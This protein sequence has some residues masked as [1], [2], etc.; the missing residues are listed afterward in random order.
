MRHVVHD[1]LTILNATRFQVRE[2]RD[3][4]NSLL[5]YIS[6]TYMEYNSN[7]D[8]L[9]KTIAH[10]TIFSQLHAHLSMFITDVHYLLTEVANHIQNLKL[11]LNMLSLRHLSPS[12]ITPSL[13][14][15]TLTDIQA[16]LPKSMEL[17]QNPSTNLWEYY[18]FLQCSTI[19]DPNHIIILIDIPLLDSFNKLEVYH[20]F[21]L[22]IFMNATTSVKCTTCNLVAKYHLEAS[23]IAINV[24]RTRY[25]FITENELAPCSHPVNKFCH[26]K[27]P[28]YPI[29]RSTHCVT[30][31]FMA[32]EDKIHKYCKTDVS[33]F[34]QL[35]QAELIAEGL[36]V[37][38]TYS[39]I[40]FSIVCGNSTLP[41]NH[42]TATPPLALVHL[43][44]SCTAFSDFLTLPSF[45]KHSSKLINLHEFSNAFTQINF[46]AISI[47]KPF[48][49]PFPIKHNL[50]IPDQ[51]M[52]IK[53]M[54]LDKLIHE[55]DS[56]QPVT[57]SPNFFENRDWKFFG[58]NTGST[59]MFIILLFL[60]YKVF[61][62]IKFQCIK[63][64]KASKSDIPNSTVPTIVSNTS[65]INAPVP[66]TSP[67]HHGVFY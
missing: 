28:I 2:N 7:F 44:L 65:L 20:I 51:L 19:I 31:L 12:T 8:A 29:N 11:Q 9:T 53:Q 16:H 41:S 66:P 64:S 55:I 40:F 50:T 10:T 23:A 13:L 24:E 33:T 21:N 17:P 37:I 15:S 4:L 62:L 26:L 34:F 56:V 49:L 59:I 67:N 52:N 48:H 25:M 43:D 61:Q 18:Q 27:S 45:H 36:W 58:F 60:T 32:N 54:P 6:R 22:P 35:P 14:R 42:I 3:K 5:H 38:A 57:N 63:S 1:S 47:W 46:S 39:K 30:A